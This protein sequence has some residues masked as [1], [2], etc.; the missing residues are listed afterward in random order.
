MLEDVRE[1]GEDGWLAIHLEGLT[2]KP[3]SLSNRI[4]IGKTRQ[5]LL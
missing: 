4:T 1:T 5:Y 3:N 2:S